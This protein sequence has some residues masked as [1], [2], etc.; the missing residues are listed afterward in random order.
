MKDESGRELSKQSI[1]V[2]SPDEM[3]VR[4]V[5]R[6]FELRAEGYRQRSVMKLPGF[7]QPLKA[8]KTKKTGRVS[9]FWRMPLTAM[10]IKN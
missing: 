6:E 8:W 4:Q 1:V 9:C 7:A 5:L 3:K 10:T 2:R